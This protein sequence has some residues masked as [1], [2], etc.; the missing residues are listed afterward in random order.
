MDGQQRTLSFCQYLNGDFAINSK[1]FHNLPKDV[2]DVILNEELLV[3][4][5]RGTESEKLEWFKTINIAGEKLTDQEL[6]NAAYT[7][8]WLADAKK[9]FSKTGCAAYSLGQSYLTG[10]AIRQDYLETVLYWI[11]TGED[12]T[13]EEYMAEHQHDTDA[14]ALWEYFRSVINW[15]KTVFPKYRKEMKGLPWGCFYNRYH[16][17]TFDPVAIEEQITALMQDEDVTN[18]KGIYEYVLDGN[19][20][21]LN[22]RAFDEK[23]KRIGFERQ[24]GYCPRCRRLKKSTAGHKFSTPGEMHADHMTAHKHGGATTLT[25]LVM[26]CPECNEEKSGNNEFYS[27]EEIS[28]M[29]KEYEGV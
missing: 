28:E 22:I 20:R 2:Q 17:S 14:T 25:N 16:T 10:T 19:E 27:E 24:H 21:H 12:K 1:Y 5:F 4:V 26:L 6:R 23:Q 29:I 13:I 7:G 15:V 9:H 3:N 18:H 11:S 8:P